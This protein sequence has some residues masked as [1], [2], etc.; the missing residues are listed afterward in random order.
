MRTQKAA[1]K[2]SAKSVSLLDQAVSCFFFAESSYFDLG[3]WNM[4][5]FGTYNL[6]SGSANDL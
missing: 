4:E 2:K 3:Q 5:Y 6:P 1:K